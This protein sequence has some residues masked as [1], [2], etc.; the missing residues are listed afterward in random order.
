[1]DNL[2]HRNAQTLPSKDHEVS[3]ASRKSLHHN[4]NR[5]KH[6]SLVPTL[7]FTLHTDRT[8]D[9]LDPHDRREKTFDQAQELTRMHSSLSPGNHDRAR[10]QDSSARDSQTRKS[11]IKNSSRLPSLRELG[12]RSLP[13]R[14]LAPSI[15][16]KAKGAP[17]MV[18]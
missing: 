17:L 12:D 3:Y 11:T 9:A 2:S 1:M 5:E 14:S 8:S 7:P 18:Y 4:E 16:A 13:D 10:L 15:S 6:N